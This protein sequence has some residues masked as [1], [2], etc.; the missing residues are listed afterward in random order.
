MFNPRVM[1]LMQVCG[2]DGA[3][4]LFVA[5]FRREELPEMPEAFNYSIRLERA[6]QSRHL[7]TRPGYGRFITESFRQRPSGPRRAIGAEALCVVG[8]YAGGNGY[9]VEGLPRCP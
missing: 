5:R 3:I 7:T 8:L 1:A 6:P 9:C 4:S 2:C